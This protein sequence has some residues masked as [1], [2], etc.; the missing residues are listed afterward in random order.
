[1]PEISISGPVG[2]IEGRFHR[3]EE[4][5]APLVIFLHHHPILGGTMNNPVIHNLY[6]MFVD[7]NFSALRFNFRGVGRSVGEF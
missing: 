7:R 1:M 4:Q 3:S 5:N 2:R 6:Y